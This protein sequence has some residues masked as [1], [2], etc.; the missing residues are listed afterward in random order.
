MIALNIV[1]DVDV[2]QIYAKQTGGRNYA[3]QLSEPLDKGKITIRRGQ[4][5]CSLSVGVSVPEKSTRKN[6]KYRMHLESI[7]TGSTITSIE[8]PFLQKEVGLIALSDSP[9]EAIDSFRQLIVRVQNHMK[10]L[11]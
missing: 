4:G 5:G 2:S 6:S 11:V 10:S 9:D 1:P 3:F 7:K 8:Y